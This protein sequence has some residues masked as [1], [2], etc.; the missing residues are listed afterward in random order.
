MGIQALHAYLNSHLA[1]FFFSNR[2]AALPVATFGWH[3]AMVGRQ[4]VARRSGQATDKYDELHDGV[5]KTSDEPMSLAESN[6]VMHGWVKPRL[7]ATIANDMV[8]P[9]QYDQITCT[10]IDADFRHVFKGF[11]ACFKAK[12]LRLGAES[13]EDD[14]NENEEDGNRMMIERDNDLNR[15]SA[16]ATVGS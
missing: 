12:V 8:F 11:V 6:K 10:T 1:S 14:E 13:D 2:H 3:A 9:G 16:S 5:V 15:R 7:R 4:I